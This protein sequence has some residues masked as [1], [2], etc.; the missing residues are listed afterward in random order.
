MTEE[1]F[2]TTNSGAPVASDDHSLS[3]G[4]DGPLALHDH[5]LVEKLAQFNRERIP[6]RVVHAKGGG[7]FGLFT[8]TADVSAYTRAALFQPGVET[9]ML[10]RFST[11]AG[12]QGSPDTWRDPRGFALKF[13][14]SEGNYD[15]VGNNTP[16]FF[17]RDGIKFPDFIRSQKRLPGSHL[18]DHDM[19]WDF[20][21]LS[22]ESAHQVTWLMGD[23]GLPSSWRH[24][25]GFG[26]HTYQWIN[27]AGE[28]FWVKYHFKTDQGVEILTQEQADQ[29]A[30]EDADFHIRDL[31][32]AIDRGDFPSWTLSVQVMP[33]EDA[34]SYRFNP[35]DLT[36]VWPHSDYPLIEVGTMTLD[37]NPENYFA[38]IEQAAFAPSNFVPGIAASPDKMLLARIFSYAD[39]HRYRVGTNHAQLPVNA[40]KSPVHSYSKDGPMRFDFQKSEVPV[41]APNSQGGAHADPARAA[42]SAGWSTDGELTRA[43]A[44]LHPEDDDFGQAR[45]LYRDVLD[46]DARARLV[47]NIAGHVSKVTRP[48]LRQRVL[49]YWANVDSSL[50]Q[51]VA[52]A[53]EPSAPGADVSA[54]AVGIGA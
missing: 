22:P 11:V 29:I 9:E 36:K 50:S 28:R 7:A 26:S 3:V 32:S 5:Y 52:E 34:K 27:A 43:A 19:Q 4:A 12:E 21:T 37:R 18:R 1:R 40:P 45:T 14:T 24:M 48:E 2:T 35:F 54:E 20:W 8:T 10:A 30:G 51:R 17:L 15:L 49:Q 42:E 25:D 46:D 33:Y 16:V 39:A 41:Y 31:S 38:Q 47:A 53:L 6:E 23:R 44:T 13:Y